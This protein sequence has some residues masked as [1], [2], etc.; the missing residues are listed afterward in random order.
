[1]MIEK[2]RKLLL[3]YEKRLLNIRMKLKNT[4]SITV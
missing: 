4:I 1:M 2:L 3:H